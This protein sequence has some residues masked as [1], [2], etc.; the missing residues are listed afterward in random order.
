MIS[1]ANNGDSRN[2]NK[3]WVKKEFLRYLGES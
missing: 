2:K 1:N 3:D